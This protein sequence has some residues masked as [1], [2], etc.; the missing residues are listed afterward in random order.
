VGAWGPGVFSDDLVCDVRDAFRDLIADG[1]TPAQATALLREEYAESVEDPDEGSVFLFALAATQ[2]RTGHVDD[3][4]IRQA[5]D[6]LEA[7]R[8]LERWD[9]AAD[10]RRRRKSLDRLAE[11]L[12]TPPRKP[13]RI[14]RRVKQDTPLEVGDVVSVPSAHGRFL[15]AVVGSHEDKGG[16]APRMKVLPFINELPA[17]EDLRRTAASATREE[18]RELRAFF[19]VFNDD[20]APTG[21]P[22]EIAVVARAVVPEAIESVGETVTWWPRFGRDAQRVLAAYGLVRSED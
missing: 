21:L 17:L 3:S 7:G 8:G 5:V 1:H 14:K 13:V 20:S 4:V 15:A 6:V 16:R 9:D 19:V 11:Q 18:V 2:W 10:R 12:R 22:E